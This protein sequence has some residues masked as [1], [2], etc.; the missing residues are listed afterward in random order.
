LSGTRLEPTA[1]A[2]DRAEG[3]GFG[4]TVK[5]IDAWPCPLREPEIVTQLESVVTVQVQSRAVETV[6]VPD[7]PTALK[8]P[9]ELL[10]VIAHRTSDVGAVTAVWL[11]LQAIE[12]A[13]EATATRST[14]LKPDVDR[15]ISTVPDARMHGPRQNG[16]DSSAR[17]AATVRVPGTPG[18]SCMG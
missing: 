2:P 18:S 3:T 9:V 1:I 8:L 13:D 15:C 4:A 11:E 14:V 6:S 16:P 10:A 5:G 7:P 12:T 17:I